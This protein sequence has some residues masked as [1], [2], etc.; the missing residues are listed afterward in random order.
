MN[1]QEI[2]SRALGRTPSI[3][4]GLAPPPRVSGS[5]PL[6]G[7]LA[8]FLRH[9]LGLLTR[10][11]E[12]QGEVAWLTIG[13]KKLCAIFGPEGHEAVFR[14]PDKL[15]NPQDAYGFM[16]PIFGEGV[17]YDASLEKMGEQVRMLLPALK[18]KRMRTYAQ[19]IVKEVELSISDWGDE[20]VI[21]L[22]DYCRVLT[23]YTSARC[24]LGPEFREG[25]NEEFARIYHDLERG[26]TPIA[27]LNPYLPLPAFRRR[28]KARARL[29]ELVGQIMDSRRRDAREGD[30]FLQTLMESR[31]ANGR[32]LSKD[33]VTGLL[34][35][36]MFAGHHT[37]SVTTA[38]ALLELLRDRRYME[39]VVSEI[40]GVFGG[41]RP[42]D[43]KSVRELVQTDN[44]VKETLRMHPPLFLLIR[45][46]QQDWTFRDYFIPKGTWIVVSPTVS[47]L[48][49]R[50]FENPHDFD[51][52]RFS[53]ERSD[54]IAPWAYVP[55][56]G[57]RHKCLGNAF[58]ILQI[59]SILA[60]LLSRYE[61]DL[62]GDPIED[63]YQSMVIGPK[64]PCRLRYR[65]RE[66]VTRV[67]VSASSDTAP[68]TAPEAPAGCPAH[69]VKSAL[70]VR[71]DKDLCQGHAV[72]HGEAPEVFDV[73]EDGKVMMVLDAPDASHN[74]AILEAVK[75][76]PTGAI[77]AE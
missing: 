49:Q 58:A 68:S 59:K 63:D 26:I 11:H 17:V 33:E 25:M 61:F 21:D 42:V 31:Y 36:A 62:R 72:C 50:Y 64:E 35:A 66:R 69:E 40:D 43:M 18:D 14:S 16:T 9:P 8:D 29:V 76:C 7:H 22:V 75:Y 57:G 54:A 48:S 15:L 3:P 2:M 46:A 67:A 34:L 6:V 12:E 30:D 65:R 51:P 27:Y 47:H 52:D 38:W 45:V 39:R 70:T 37:S 53:S 10:A 55:F 32:E 71:L 23:N 44:A 73:G 77:K 60:I 56:G 4:E 74:A 20:G 13:P 19:S 28:D 5:L 24:L 1:V 41:G